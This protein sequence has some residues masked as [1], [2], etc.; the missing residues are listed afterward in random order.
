MFNN[1]K[2]SRMAA[3]VIALSLTGWFLVS[4]SPTP[5]A[6]G[7]PVPMQA[8]MMKMGNKGMD[9]L[10][11]L[12]GKE[13]DVAY[14]SQ[15]I[16][17]HRAAIDM[18]KQVIATASDSETKSGAQQVIDVQG[19]QIEEM[20]KWLKDWHHVEPSKEQQALVVEDM[21]AMLAMPIKDQRSYYEMMIPHHQGAIDMSKLVVGR[22]EMVSVKG[23][24]ERIIKEQ[25]SEISKYE[26][27]LKLGPKK[28][29]P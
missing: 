27:F 17:H 1:T 19:S 6:G 25:T 21:K 18:A 13:F 2:Y 7:T 14:L 29:N 16:A 5:G 10:K 8:E 26:G 4:C 23:L 20:T 24:A 22:A 3:P 12:K 28:L 11:A 9:A 15:M